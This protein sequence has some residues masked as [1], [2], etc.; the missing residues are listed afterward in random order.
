[1]ADRTIA[2]GRL[3]SGA[4]VRVHIGAGTWLTEVANAD[5]YVHWQ[6]TDGLG[7]SDVLVLAEG[8]QEYLHHVHWL[9][10]SDPI[11]H[12]RPMNEQKNI[13][14][15]ELPPLTPIAPPLPVL[16]IRGTNFVDRDEN[17]FVWNGCDQFSAYRKFLDDGP[18]ALTDLLHESNE[19]GFTMWRC[20]LMGDITQNF[21]LELRPSRSGFYEGLLP[22]VN[23]L[24]QHGIVLLATVFVDVETILA[25]PLERMRHW[26]RVADRLR[27]SACL[28]SGG[29]EWSHRGNR[30]NPAELSD[31]GMLWSRG[32]DVGDAA[33]FMPTGSFA[34]FHPRRDLPAALLDS[35]AS[36]VTLYNRGLT[37]PLIIDE[38]PRM[39]TDGSGA[40]YTDPHLCW[41]FARHYA[42]ETA[43]ACLHTRAGQKSELMDDVTRRCAVAWCRG[44]QI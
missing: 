13:G 19:L 8:Y 38:P 15:G 10:T 12:P 40:E 7:D 29:N 18:D 32:S 23:L 24:N 17:R 21:L 14:E 41:R 5:G 33:P 6:V 9:T 31:P 3:P 20:L 2:L 22:F 39:G 1:M 16:Q 42:T 44:M 27:G 36:P 11:Q 25:T 34:E 4:E 43:G 26:L 30:F 28:L 37:V 35:V